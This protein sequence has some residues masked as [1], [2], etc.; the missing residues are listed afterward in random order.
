MFWI[1]LNPL[2]VLYQYLWI[3]VCGFNEIELRIFA[4]QFKKL[5]EKHLFNEFIYKLILILNALY[6]KCVEKYIIHFFFNC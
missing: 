6:L 4:I 3:E 2:I 5:F 1:E